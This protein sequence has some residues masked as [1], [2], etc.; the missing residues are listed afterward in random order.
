MFLIELMRQQK[1]KEV[2]AKK[3]GIP[4]NLKPKAANFLATFSLYWIIC[5]FPTVVLNVNKWLLDVCALHWV[6]AQ[7]IFCLISV[8]DH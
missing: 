8:S 2:R 3:V 7:R 4:K 1:E 6:H 5:D